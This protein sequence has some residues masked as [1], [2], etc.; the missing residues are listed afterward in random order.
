MGV[1]ATRSRWHSR[2]TTVPGCRTQAGTIDLANPDTVVD[3]VAKYLAYVKE[4]ALDEVGASGWL[5]HDIRWCVTVPAIWS[6]VERERVRR[7]ATAAGLPGDDLLIAIE[8]EAAALHCSDMV[9]V[10]SDGGIADRLA[11]QA[12]GT[13]FMVVDGGGGTVD[14]SAHRTTIAENGEIRLDDIGVPVGEKLGSEYLNFAF[15][16]TVLTDRFGAETL[17]RLEKECLV[18]L[19]ELEEAWEKEKRTL[20]ASLDENGVRVTERVQITVPGEVW[21][22][23]EAPVRERLAEQAGGRNFRLVMKSDEVRHLFDT[24]VDEILE[25]IEAQHR[26]APGDRTSR[27]GV[28]AARRW[29]LLLGLPLAAGAPPICRP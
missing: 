14:L 17:E 29:F 16:H 13:R 11:L 10:R 24:V 4:V 25:R 20:R 26:D 28:P 2:S 5:M 22:L 12:A 15:R 19:T 1:T 18:G 23:L 7:A 3:L 27:R 8:P 21:V 9:D 6:D